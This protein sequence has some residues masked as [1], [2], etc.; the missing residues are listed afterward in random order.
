MRSDINSRLDRLENLLNGLVERQTIARFDT[1]M[2]LTYS[3][4]LAGSAELFNVLGQVRAL[5]DAKI[6]GV[7]LQSL[8]LF[9]VFVVGLGV[10]GWFVYFL[11]AYLRDDLR[12]RIRA[13]GGMLGQTIISLSAVVAILLAASIESPVSRSSSFLQILIFVLLGLV[14]MFPLL[15]AVSK[16]VHKALSWF[17]TN[18]P[19]K[20]ADAGV[21]RW[22]K[23]QQD[24]TGGLVRM[25]AIIFFIYSGTVALSFWTPSSGIRNHLLI[26]ILVALVGVII[27]RKTLR[28][29]IDRALM[30]LNH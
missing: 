16:L 30:V 22:R 4:I 18:A 23:L 11:R 14:V 8:V 21:P 25:T 5:R 28:C 20:S 3:S 15:V 9:L 26:A 27:I 13:L 7:S 19:R 1:A 29:I 12:R 17:E 24:R 10:V 6:F 2:F